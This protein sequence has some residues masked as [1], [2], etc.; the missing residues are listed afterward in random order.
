VPHYGQ[1][2]TPPHTRIQ[3]MPLYHYIN[4]DCVKLAFTKTLASGHLQFKSAL[5]NDVTIVN[6]HTH[7]KSNHF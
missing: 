3:S 5:T 4:S 1:P 2:I 6:M 7:S